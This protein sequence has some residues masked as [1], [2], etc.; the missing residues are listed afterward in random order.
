[1]RRSGI[2]LPLFSLPSPYGCGCFSDDAKAFLDFLH[3]AGQSFWQILP[4]GPAGKGY[5]PYLPLSVFAGDPLFID[6]DKLEAMGYLTETETQAAKEEERGPDPRRIDYKRVRWSRQRLLSIAYRRFMSSAPASTQT[7]FRAF[8]KESAPWLED[9]AL[10]METGA[11]FRTPSWRMWPRAIR[12]RDPACLARLREEWQDDLLRWKWMQFEFFRQWRDIKEY[13]NRKG[14]EII[15]DVPIYVSPEGADVWARPDL[16]RLDKT[17]RPCPVAGCPPDLFSREGQVWGNPLYRW[18]DRREDVFSWW[19]R[20][21]QGRFRLYDIIRLD[22][23]RGFESFYAIPGPG[24]DAREGHWEKGPGLSFFQYLEKQ[25]PK[26]RF[27]AEDLG[28]LTPAFRAF[29]EATAYPGMEVLQFAFDGNPA[30]PYLPEHHRE[31]AV[32]YTGTHDTDTALGWASHLPPQKREEIRQRMKKRQMPTAEEIAAYLLAE[33]EGS[34]AKIC[35]LPMQ[36]VL[37]EGSASRTNVPGV[38]S[39]NW[40]YRLPDHAFA[41]AV[42]ERMARLTAR[43]DRGM[44]VT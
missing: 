13:A 22:H 29:Q 30:N 7:A 16:F 17:L 43:A 42:A 3:R 36:D 20:R 39:G 24:R 4:L 23:F 14:I 15:G 8:C 31:N 32:V 11:R 9:V 26:A 33:A 41:E 44:P 19:A 38:R 2:L 6:P 40:V 34:R 25:I 35:I 21:L 37:G 27:I 10:F 12:K 28:F 18:Q 1:M 5:S